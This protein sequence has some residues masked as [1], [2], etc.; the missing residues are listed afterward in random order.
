MKKAINVFK[1]EGYK[2]VAQRIIDRLMF[3]VFVVACQVDSDLL[4]FTN[5]TDPTVVRALKRC[6]AFFKNLDFKEIYEFDEDEII[7][8]TKIDPWRIPARLSIEKL[9]E[10]W[11]CYVAKYKGRIIASS[12]SVA[13]PEFYEPYLRRTLSLANDE[14]YTWRGF[15]VPDY[16]GRG[17]H[18]W[19]GN[20]VMDHLATTQGIK[21]YIG[22]VRI[23]NLA[24]LRTLKQTG[25]SVV[26][27]IGFIDGLGYR[28]HYVWGKKAFKCTKKR[29]FIERKG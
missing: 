29:I 14:V 19:L 20:C 6:Q 5:V 11:C 4:A 21:N 26:G 22:F 7:E 8:L 28:L 15:C 25:W 1:N 2:G 23:N 10:G 16:R 27:R 13:G 3:H 12:W 9:K 17:V 24:Q 18:I